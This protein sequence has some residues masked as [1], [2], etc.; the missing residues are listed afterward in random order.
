MLDDHVSKRRA[1][2]SCS[3]SGRENQ[4]RGTKETEIVVDRLGSAVLI[5]KKMMIS[6][7]KKKV[8][9]EVAIDFA[10]EQTLRG[11]RAFV[12]A[13]RKRLFVEVAC[14]SSAPLYTSLDE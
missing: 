2:C 4:T 6:M 10:A 12:Q 13:G 9:F 11:N 3:V 8:P 1:G 5:W 14:K 7:T